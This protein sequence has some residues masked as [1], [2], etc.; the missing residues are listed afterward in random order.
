MVPDVLVRVAKGDD[1]SRITASIPATT[2]A[3]ELFRR[4][5]RTKMV[6][7]GVL[8]LHLCE[9]GWWYLR[10]ARD[11]RS[12]RRCAIEAL[13][14]RPLAPANHGLLLATLAPMSWLDRLARLKHRIAALRLAVRSR[15]V[16]NLHAQD[17]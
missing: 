5:H 12:A 15:R 16:A 17:C 13:R 9:S 11:T 14:F 10:G 3:R 4:K 1:R 2:Q 8:H 7:E 6:Q